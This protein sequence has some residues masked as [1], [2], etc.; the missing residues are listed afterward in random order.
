MLPLMKKNMWYQIIRDAG[1]SIFK[2][3]SWL[4]LEE[5][6]LEKKK[7][8]PVNTVHLPSI[9]K[10]IP[11]INSNII[12]FFIFIRR[13]ISRSCTTLQTKNLGIAN[14]K[15]LSVQNPKKK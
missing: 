3:T 9:I 2:N 7:Q 14:A 4:E 8:I 15:M 5:K 13:N 10:H 1:L 12:V 6:K 11:K